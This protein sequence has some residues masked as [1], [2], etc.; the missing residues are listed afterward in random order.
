VRHCTNGAERGM[1]GR[2]YAVVATTRS[3]T[4]LQKG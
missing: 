1:I 3:N 2:G 4:L